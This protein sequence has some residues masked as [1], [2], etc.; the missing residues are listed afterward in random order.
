MA[1]K[2]G[3]YGVSSYI[4][5]SNVKRKGRHSKKDKNTYKGQEDNG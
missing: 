1:K 3:I 4:K 5:K 2:K